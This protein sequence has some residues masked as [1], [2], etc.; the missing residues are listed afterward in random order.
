MGKKRWT[1]SAWPS[2]PSGFPSMSVKENMSCGNGFMTTWPLLTGTREPEIYRA[3]VGAPADWL[4]GVGV[5]PPEDTLVDLWQEE[6]GLEVAYKDGTV[7][8]IYAEDMPLLACVVE[9]MRLFPG[10]TLATQAEEIGEKKWNA[11]TP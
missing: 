1:R 5:E 2:P 9:A 7:R 6:K 10:S 3:L 4:R 11:K 8:R